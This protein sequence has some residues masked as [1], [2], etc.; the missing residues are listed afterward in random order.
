MS[1]SRS[2][3][4]NKIEE[5]CLLFSYLQDK[6]LVLIS[7]FSNSKYGLRILEKYK[8]YQNIILINGLYDK[9]KLDLIRRNCKAYIHT[10]TLCGSAPSLIEMIVCRVPIYSIDV[11]QNRYTLGKCG[12]YFSNFD[13]LQIMLKR[14]I[15][16]NRPNKNFSLQYDWQTVVREYES[17]L[18]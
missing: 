6:K 4:D 7:N 11:I 12:S 17:L 1:I 8:K 5:L 13:E 10:H 3:A 14:D 16:P 15:M 2:I 9:P 18:I